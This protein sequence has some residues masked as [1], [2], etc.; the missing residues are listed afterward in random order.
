MELPQNVTFLQISNCCKVWRVIIIKFVQ[1]KV[2]LQTQQTPNPFAQPPDAT[3]PI[4]KN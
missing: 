4:K 2:N 3:P 1:T